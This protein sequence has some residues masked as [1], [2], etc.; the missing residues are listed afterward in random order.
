M[1]L[2]AQMSE[3]TR[4]ARHYPAT[5]RPEGVERF[6]Q[7]V[8]IGAVRYRSCVMV[9]VGPQG[10]YLWVRPPLGRSLA[11]LI[12]WDEVR[13][14]QRTRLYGRRAMRLSIGNPVVGT[15]TVYEELFRLMVPYLSHDLR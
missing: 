2:F 3:L 11:V 8:K 4:L 9:T 6:K 15:V 12:P 13:E 5:E 7:T 14:I 1:P 10:F